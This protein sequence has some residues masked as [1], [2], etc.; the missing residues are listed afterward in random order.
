[1]N[2]LSH[3]DIEHHYVFATNRISK[4]QFVG[5]IKFTGSPTARYCHETCIIGNDAEFQ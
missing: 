2:K 1:M 5:S 3:P 4:I